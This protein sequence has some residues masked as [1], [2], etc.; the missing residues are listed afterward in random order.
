MHSGSI[1]IGHHQEHNPPDFEAPTLVVPDPV[2]GELPD[3]GSG[4]Q[5]LHMW[6]FNAETTQC[7]EMLYRGY[8]GTSNMFATRRECERRCLRRYTTGAEEVGPKIKATVEHKHKT[9]KRKFFSE[10]LDHL[11]EQHHQTNGQKNNLHL[12]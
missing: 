2:C 11:D 7:R 6:Y 12:I 8:G 1:R 9:H 3:S 5:F 4:H 10:R